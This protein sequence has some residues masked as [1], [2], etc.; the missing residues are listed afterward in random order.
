MRYDDDDLL[1]QIEGLRTYRKGE[2][3][4]PHK[5]LLLLFAI[6]ELLQGRR[7]LPFA[8]VERALNPL[9][10]AYAPPVVARHQPELP[11]WH[12]SSDGL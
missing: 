8:D 2:R 4:A 11:Y 3:R 6:A 10:K 5:P 12:L 1:Q 9:L 7:R